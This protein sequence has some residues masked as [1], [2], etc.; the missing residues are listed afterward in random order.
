VEDE[1][2]FYDSEIDWDPCGDEEYIDEL[3]PCNQHCGPACSE[4]GGDGLCMLEIRAQ[5]EEEKYFR[6]Q[7]WYDFLSGVRNVVWEI[8]RWFLN[9]WRKIRP[10]KSLIN[11]DDLPF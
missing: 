9:V 7:K 4:W 1:W 2:E 8:Q 10:V 11:M 6:H 3:Y 5:M